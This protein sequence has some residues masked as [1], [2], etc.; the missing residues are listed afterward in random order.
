[1]ASHLGE[2]VDTLREG[3]RP[4]SARAGQGEPP[5]NWTEATAT[6]PTD[7]AAAPFLDAELPPP[8]NDD[9]LHRARAFA[10]VVGL[11]DCVQPAPIRSAGFRL[12]PIRDLVAA[13][14][15]RQRAWGL[16]AG[17][18][19]LVDREALASVPLDPTFLLW[20]VNPAD[21]SATAFWEVL[22]CLRRTPRPT[23]LPDVEG[24]SAL[25]GEEA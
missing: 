21:A 20:L 9:L 16:L 4:A 1:M 13:P 23:R 25:T 11:G 22:T 8:E 19:G 5:A 10:D 14:P 18:S 17:V 15:E 6:P 3:L 24:D 7:E 2:T 12:V